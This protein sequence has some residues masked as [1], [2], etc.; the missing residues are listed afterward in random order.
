MNQV[1]KNCLVFGAS[2]CAGVLLSKGIKKVSKEVRK[3]TKETF[4]NCQKLGE[5]VLETPEKRNKVGELIVAAGVGVALIGV[6]VTDH[7]PKKLTA[8]EKNNIR[9]NIQCAGAIIFAAGVL[10]PK[11]TDI[12]KKGEE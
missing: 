9:T 2:V 12:E 5:V 4:D 10:L 7:R 1:V 6:A 11:W 3:M 8:Q